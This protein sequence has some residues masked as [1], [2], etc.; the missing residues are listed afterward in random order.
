MKEIVDLVPDS[1]ENRQLMVAV[2]QS[3]DKKPRFTFAENTPETLSALL[4]DYK[5][6]V[7]IATPHFLGEEVSEPYAKSLTS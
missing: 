7:E 5:D 6:F 3:Y 1:P 2:V 4:S